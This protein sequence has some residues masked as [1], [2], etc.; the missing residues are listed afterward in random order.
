MTRYEP[1]HSLANAEVEKPEVAN[2][3]A[4]DSPQAVPGVA[5]VVNDKR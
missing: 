5:K 3:R 4:D 1:R 2:D